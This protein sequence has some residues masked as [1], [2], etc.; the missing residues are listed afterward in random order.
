M[1]LT[2]TLTMR[3]YNQ[4]K[5]AE[6]AEVVELEA[7]ISSQAQLTMAVEVAKRETEERERKERAEEEAKAV[8]VSVFVLSN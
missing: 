8:Q 3:I 2:Y 1:L 7:L 4:D 6:L 5:N